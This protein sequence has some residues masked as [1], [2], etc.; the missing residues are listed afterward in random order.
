MEIVKS[1]HIIKRI[2]YCFILLSGYIDFGSIASL[3]VF[4]LVTHAI[5]NAML[6]NDRD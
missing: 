1:H 5:T 6:Q 4:Y 3:K 2:E